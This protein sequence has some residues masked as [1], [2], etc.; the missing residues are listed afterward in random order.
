LVQAQWCR[1]QSD[2]EYNWIFCQLISGVIQ[3]TDGKDR[4]MLLRRLYLESPM[5]TEDAISMLKQ[6]I[7]V[8]TN[9]SIIW[10][11]ILHYKYVAGN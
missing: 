5:I 3:Q 9:T 4:Q 10:Y 11:Q 8:R 7:Q 2:S 6:F 1:R